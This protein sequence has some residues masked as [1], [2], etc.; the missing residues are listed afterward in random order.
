M[1]VP[2]SFYHE[3]AQICATRAAETDLPMLREKYERAGAAWRALASRESDIKAA[4]DRRAS[5][6]ARAAAQAQLA[7]LQAS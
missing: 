1:S 7:Q 2:D 4:R 3:Q 6:V 5:D